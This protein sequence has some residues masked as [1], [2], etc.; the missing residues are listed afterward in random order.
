MEM[1]LVLLNWRQAM[2]ELSGLEGLVSVK[3]GADSSAA[4]RAFCRSGFG[5]VRPE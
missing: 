5:I 4:R 3:K 1:A 2:G